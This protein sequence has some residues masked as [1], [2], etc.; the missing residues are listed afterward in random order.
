MAN[1][2]PLMRPLR[3]DSLKPR[4]STQASWRPQ[5]TVRTC[6]IPELSFAPAAKTAFWAAQESMVKASPDIQPADE[7][8]KAEPAVP[9]ADPFASA[10]EPELPE[11]CAEPAEPALTF[12]VQ[13]LQDAE[14]A[15]SFAEAAAA[16]A[17]QPEQEARPCPEEPENSLASSIALLLA[18][19]NKEPEVQEID[20]SI[21]AGSSAHVLADEEA[22]PEPVQQ[23]DSLSASIATLLSGAEDD[24][25]EDDDEYVQMRH[26][27]VPD[28]F[29]PEPA[30]VPLDMSVPRRKK[31]W[32]LW[33]IAPVVLAAGAY[34]AWKCGYL[35]INLP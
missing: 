6:E 2:H 1:E 26:D 7:L 12:A 15:E 14:P 16:E 5:E 27:A 22:A 11:V 29:I 25:D 32:W 17:E 19:Q 9:E 33:L 31:R 28:R 3:S 30:C 20:F 21:F 24:D 4:P 13:D 8:E 10:F 23:E 34:A 18:N 35:P